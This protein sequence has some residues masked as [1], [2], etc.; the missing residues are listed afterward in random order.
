M[1]MK[2]VEKKT[3]IIEDTLVY[4]RRTY[5][6]ENYWIKVFQRLDEHGSIISVE[7]S[8]KQNGNQ[9]IPSIYFNENTGDNEFRIQTTSYGALNMAE[10]RTFLLAQQEALLTV[11]ELRKIVREIKAETPSIEVYT[12][13]KRK[14]ASNNGT[15]A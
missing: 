1:T 12:E 7:A 15:K 11:T 9:Y 13:I 3:R 10:Y 6:T 5:E 4:I 2:F 8:S 14:A